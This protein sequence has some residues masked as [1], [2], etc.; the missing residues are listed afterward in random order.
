MDMVTDLPV[1]PEG[2]DSITVF[3]D[4]LSKMVHL[5]PCKKHMYAPDL[6]TLFCEH[7]FRS[8][9]VPSQFV[10]DRGS[11]FVSRFWQAFTELLGVTT[12]MSSAYHP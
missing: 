1:T 8:H 12:A 6:A 11:L 10:S 5:A 3:V 7:V 4:R 2:Y 9:G